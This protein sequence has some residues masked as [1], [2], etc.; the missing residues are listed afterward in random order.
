MIRAALYAA[1][2][3]TTAV[4]GSYLSEIVPKS[5]WKFV[6][7]SANYSSWQ[8]RLPESKRNLFGA[9]NPS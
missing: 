3:R 9:G 7:Q 5:F 8:I 2:A 1:S 6:I 4:F